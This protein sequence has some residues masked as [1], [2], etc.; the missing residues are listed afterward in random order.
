LKES[1]PEQAA[2]FLELQ[3]EEDGHRHRLLDHSKI[4]FGDHVPL[5]RRDNVRGFVTRRPVWL[6]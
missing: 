3:K 2:K 1:C 6:I 5:I 4:R